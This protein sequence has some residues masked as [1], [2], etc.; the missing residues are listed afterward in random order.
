MSRTAGEKIE[1]KY[2]AHFIDSSFGGTPSYGR[3]GKDLEELNIELNPDQEST[4][5]IIGE[6]SVNVRGYEPEYDV[7]TYYCY[8]GDALYTQL[9]S[10]VNNRS[11]G[12]QLATTVI[13]AILDT[14]GTVA[15]AYKEDVLVVPQSI[16]GDTGGMQIPFNVYYNGNRGSVTG[17]ITGGK[18]VIGA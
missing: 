11:T 6:T 16:G 2:L 4:K 13:D 5:N 12:S 7:E 17:T 1:R 18:F 10:I 15:S 3:L 8:E 9:L 14:D